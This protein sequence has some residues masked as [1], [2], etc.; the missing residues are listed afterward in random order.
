MNIA[1]LFGRKNSKSVRNKNVLNFYGK[2]AFSYPLE[3]ALKNKFINKIYVSTDSSEI[4]NF[5]KKKIVEL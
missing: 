3:A 5:C 4:I 1:I 2:P